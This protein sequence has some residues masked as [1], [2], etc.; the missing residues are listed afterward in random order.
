MADAFKNPKQVE[1]SELVETMKGKGLRAADVARL[2]KISKGSVSR[3][4]AGKLTPSEQ[5]L[6]L[7]RDKVAQRTTPTPYPQHGEAMIMRDEYAIRM[8]SLPPEHQRTVETIIDSLA[9]NSKVASAAR[10]S[11]PSA[12]RAARELD[13]KSLP[14]PPTGGHTSYKPKPRPGTGKR[15]TNQRPPPGQAPT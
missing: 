6:E 10:A 3:I 1:F 7:F 9:A 8:R 12:L 14:S 4:L 11:G 2:L 13:P 15:S 5:T